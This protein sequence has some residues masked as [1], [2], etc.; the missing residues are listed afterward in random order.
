MAGERCETPWRRRVRR[1]LVASAVLVTAA[2]LA[3]CRLEW[4][5]EAVSIN[6]AGTGTAHAAS[7]KPVFSPDGSKI[8]FV[9]AASDLGSTDTNAAHDVYVRDLSTNTTTLVSVTGDGTDAGNL[10]SENP[11]FSPDGTKIAF[12]SASTDLGPPDQNHSGDVYVRDLVAGTTIMVSRN[13]S[14][15][16]SGNGLHGPS[17]DPVFSPDGTTV[18]F[19][20]GG[21]QFGPPDPALRGTDFDVYLHDLTTGHTTLVSRNATGN[22]GGDGESDTP[23]F[24]PEGT[25]LYFVSR[26]T[27][28]G[29]VDSDNSSDI[30]RFDLATGA[31][32]LVTSNA[33][34]T[35]SANGWSYMPVVAPEGDSVA[36]VTDAADLGP[37]DTNGQRDVYIRD[38]ASG[39]TSLASVDAAGAD[40]G[41][42]SS[43]YDV[44]FDTTG[45]KLMFTS[46]ATNLGPTDTNSV[47]DVYVRDLVTGE[48]T[49]ASANAAGDDSGAGISGGL[50]F[51]RNGDLVLFVSFA[52]NLGPTDANGGCDLY[53]RD[54]TTGL[55]SIVSAKKNEAGAPNGYT[56]CLGTAM[57]NSDGDAVVFSSIASDLVA[58]DRNADSDVFLASL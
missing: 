51:G 27:D 34:R 57:F 53:V 3:G 11:V 46:T 50:G 26:A 38:M 9:S 47:R 19:W 54:L 55:T 20:S 30:F 33:T 48:T 18:A 21:D 39:T 5:V 32:D 31:I 58:N 7:E 41:N 44:A 2:A 17:V 1:A 15:T 8:A 35:A 40:G 22:D 12:V 45:T 10:W 13:A 23:V 16:G 43:E 52:S 24:S 42:G 37:T 49:L 28:L 4:T 36:F 6:A 25:G 56:V 29:T 14:G